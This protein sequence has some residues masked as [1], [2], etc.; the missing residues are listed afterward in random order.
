MKLA[1][2]I[3]LLSASF[4]IFLTVIGFSAVR[5]ISDVN[6]KLKELNDSRLIPIVYLENLKSDIEYIR[7]QGNYLMDAQ[8]DDETKIA[9]QKNIESRAASINKELEQYK[10]N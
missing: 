6:S 8:D 4:L 3:A 1:Q 7:T 2:K 10:N 5:Q 9:V